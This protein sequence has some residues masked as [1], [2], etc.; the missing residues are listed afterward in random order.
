MF[1]WYVIASIELFFKSVG[2]NQDIFTAVVSLNGIGKAVAF[3]TGP[4]KPTSKKNVSD[5]HVY[6]QT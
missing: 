4:I 5:T 6:R 2:G 3:S 1:T